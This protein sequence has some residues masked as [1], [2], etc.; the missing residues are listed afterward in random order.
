MDG[1]E[2]RN[3]SSCLPRPRRPANPCDEVR[4]EP[5]SRAPCTGRTARTSPFCRDH[6][7]ILLTGK[8][9]KITIPL[10][11]PFDIPDAA[12]TSARISPDDRTAP[13]NIPASRDTCTWARH[14]HDATA[15]SESGIPAT[16]ADD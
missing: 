4:K 3:R 16:A 6:A 11:N 1:C 7:R 8:V 5:P 14:R 10:L 9:R 15:V 12:A 13:A 2:P